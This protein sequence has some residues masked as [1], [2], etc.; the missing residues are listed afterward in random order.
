MTCQIC[1][2]MT[3]ISVYFFVQTGQK[4]TD[5]K[6]EREKIPFILFPLTLLSYCN[7]ITSSPRSN[8]RRSETLNDIN[9]H[10]IFFSSFPLTDGQLL[11]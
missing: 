2:F 4:K 1:S 10:S 5:G 11:R 6:G 8:G 3:R 7:G 9:N